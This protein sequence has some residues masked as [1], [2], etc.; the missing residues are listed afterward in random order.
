MAVA[1]TRWQKLPE[2]PWCPRWGVSV[3]ALPSGGILTFGGMASG[4]INPFKDCWRSNDGGL[5]W[6]ELPK[7]PF[8]P[9]STACTLAMPSGEV[10]LC[11]GAGPGGVSLRDCWLSSDGGMSWEKLPTPPWCAR[12]NAASA[13]LEDGTVLLMGGLGSSGILND[14]WRTA[15]CGRSWHRLPAPSWGCRHSSVAAVLSDRAVLLIGGGDDSGELLNEV[16]MTDDNGESW[17]ELPTPPWSARSNASAASFPSGAI[18][19]LGGWAKGRRIL[20]EEWLTID[21]CTW[22]SHEPRSRPWSARKLAAAVSLRGRHH[23]G[24]LLLGGDGLGSCLGDV[25]HVEEIISYPVTMCAIASPDDTGSIRIQCYNMA[26]RLVYVD[27]R[28]SDKCSDL[29]TM[30]SKSFGC[31]EDSLRLILSSRKEVDAS[32]DET[33]AVI[34]PAVAAEVEASSKNPET[35]PIFAGDHQSAPIRTIIRLRRFRCF[36]RCCPR[37][38]NLRND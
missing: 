7:P 9:R 20:R 35:I 19:L 24:I 29:R 23:R 21:G 1:K 15:D 6:E 2:P 14:V 25:W 5:T 28:V 13:C 30:I 22:I 12:T 17:R 33:M 38:R 11:G 10:L 18:A 36:Q 3:A 34:F 8:L 26:G 37:R 32:K 31:H 4:R 16:W 27:L